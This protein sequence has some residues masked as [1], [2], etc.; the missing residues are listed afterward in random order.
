MIDIYIL[1]KNALDTNKNI[2]LEKSDKIDFIRNKLIWNSEIYYIKNNIINKILKEIDLF[3][4][5]FINYFIK[6][7]IVDIQQNKID[8]HIINIPKNFIN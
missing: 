1:V 6:I 7:N 2:Y 5:E 4:K 3:K 8:S